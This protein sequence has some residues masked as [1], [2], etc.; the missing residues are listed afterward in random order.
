[1]RFA[2]KNTETGT[3]WFSFPRCAADK[4]LITS[5]AAVHI[6]GECCVYAKQRITTA[7][8][9]QCESDQPSALFLALQISIAFKLFLIN[10]REAFLH[11]EQI[12]TRLERFS[13]WKWGKFLLRC[14]FCVL[15]SGWD[16][17][18]QPAW[19]SWAE[20]SFVGTAEPDAF[21]IH[22]RV[23]DILMGMKNGRAA[24]WLINYKHTA[25]N[26]PGLCRKEWVKLEHAKLGS[27]PAGVFADFQF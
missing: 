6:L 26:A 2:L 5:A 12:K 7:G 19:A 11:C 16:K 10:C 8:K 1:M 4:Y 24:A 20:A 9:C 17:A 21:V 13:L 27:F 14:Q 23:Y 3:V 15:I 18:S 22:H 25:A